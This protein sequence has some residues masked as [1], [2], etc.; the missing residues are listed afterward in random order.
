MLNICKT[1][2]SLTF[3]TFDVQQFSTVLHLTPQKKGEQKR[4]RTGKI[5]E[6]V[7]QMQN[8][9]QMQN[10]KQVQNVKQMQN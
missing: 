8:A 9:K 6:I 10:V 5:L 3:V 4:I 7:K 2:K 1:E